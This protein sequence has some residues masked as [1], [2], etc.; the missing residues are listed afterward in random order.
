MRTELLPGKSRDQ[1]R[2]W[3]KKKVK[4]I[5]ISKDKKSRWNQKTVKQ[6]GI[7]RQEEWNM[8]TELQPVTRGE[9]GTRRQ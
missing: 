5:G 9:D 1:K 2:R 6:M 8:M 3:N 4:H 7:S